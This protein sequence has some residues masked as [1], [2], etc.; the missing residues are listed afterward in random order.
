[1]YKIN[2]L[3][4]LLY[5]NKEV[6]IIYKCEICKKK[7]KNL[8]RHLSNAG[9]LIHGISVEDYYLK[10][11]L[12][13]ESKPICLLCGNK[14]SFYGICG[15]FSK[16]CS[17]KCHGKLLWSTDS[18]RKKVSQSCKKTWNTDKY[19]KI[20]A[21]NSSKGWKNKSTLEKELVK[22]NNIESI[23]C[24]IIINLCELNN[25]L[26]SGKS[27]IRYL[28]R[29]YL[30]IFDE[31]KKY[32]KFLNESSSLSERLY[33]IINDI[34]EK[35]KCLECNNK[36]NFVTYNKGYNDFCSTKCSTSNQEVKNKS[37]NTC[38]KKYGGPAPIHSCHIREKIRKTNLI[39]YGTENVLQHGIIRDKIKKIFLE[40][41]G[42]EYYSK[43]FVKESVLRKVRNIDWLKNRHY[44]CKKSVLQISKELGI[45]QGYLLKK[46]NE[47]GLKVKLFPRSR[48]EKEIIGFINKSDLSSNDRSVISP[49]EL[50]IYLHGQKLAIEFNG[51]FWH[52]S[53]N[54]ESDK[55][56]KNKHLMKTEMCNKKNIKLLHIFENEWIDLI[57]QDIWKSI[58]N[59]NIG[60]KNKFQINIE[61]C[62]VKQ[63][64]N[65]KL[66][67]QF[68]NNNHLLGFINSSVKL[69]LFYKEELISLV[70]FKQ[71]NKKWEIVRF[72]N[73]NHLS[74]IGG[75]SKLF[76]Y[77]IN[78][79]NPAT[80]IAYSDRRFLDNNL[81]KQLNFKHIRDSKPNY[82]YFMKNKLVLH[83]R[84]KFNKPLK[85]LDSK[86][87]KV[88][89]IYLNGYR[90]IW[91]CG[92]AV[93]A[94]NK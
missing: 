1:M 33:C 74:V 42:H 71:I 70:A 24:W 10:Y 85:Q 63:I 57:K 37:K 48:F 93:Y 44:K 94:W 13:T 89:N 75:A 54:K 72:C 41:Y 20:A 61:K 51:L 12:K 50:D 21:L 68:L 4:L 29:N 38:I 32:T 5:I 18:H 31:I 46:F 86:L 26:I 69:G 34:K 55:K 9:K 73:K 47:L 45:S 90:R 84:V 82:F 15:G 56:M 16:T 27:Q 14:V 59:S 81:Y 92:N 52:S 49:Y 36:L 78:K 8:G 67:K 87:S 79:Y 2:I 39:K 40:K 53:D 7:Y 6:A 22:I 11:I 80:I 43:N 62:K 91:D 28:K 60:K 65:N 76:N 35:N 64:T 66:I 77:F 83:S 19:K 25:N 30:N 88:E 23:K 3:L 17:A 58:I